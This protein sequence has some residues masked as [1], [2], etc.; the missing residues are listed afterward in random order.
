[1]DTQLNNYRNG[2]KPIYFISALDGK[3][4]LHTKDEIVKRSANVD[5]L[6]GVLVKHGTKNCIISS[7]VEFSDEDGF[8]DN[9]AMDIVEKA[10]D[11]A[12][13]IRNK[14]KRAKS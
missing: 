4:L 7:S 2:M 14:T 9:D 13:E 1:M 12:K 6:A 3:I 8:P 5:E 11:K 10:I